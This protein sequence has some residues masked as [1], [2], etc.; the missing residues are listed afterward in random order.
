MPGFAEIEKNPV[1][2]YSLNL[3]GA[4][5]PKFI[6]GGVSE[7]PC[8]TVFPGSRPLNSLKTLTSLNKEVRAFKGG[9]GLQG[10]GGEIVIP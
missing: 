8:F 1:S 7:A 2:P 10:L 6:G 5:S 4:I 9:Y 3:G